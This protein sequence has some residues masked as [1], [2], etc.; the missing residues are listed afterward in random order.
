MKKQL[1]VLF[2]LMFYAAELHATEAYGMGYKCRVTVVNAS[3]NALINTQILLINNDEIDTLTT[4]VDGKITLFLDASYGCP[5]NKSFFQRMF[6]RRQWSPKQFDLY[7]NEQHFHLKRNWNRVFRK[8]DTVYF[9]L[10]VSSGQF[11]LLK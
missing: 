3:G 8:V 10:N 6:N 5:S 9:E 7:Y 11:K 4:D 1:F 2:L